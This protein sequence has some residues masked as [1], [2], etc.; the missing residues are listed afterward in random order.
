MYPEPN[1]GVAGHSIDVEDMY[2]TPADLERPP[3][4]EKHILGFKELTILPFG[5]LSENGPYE[6][7]VGSMSS[8]YQDLSS[9]RFKGKVKIK[10]LS[11]NVEANLGDSDDVATVNLIGNSLF[12]NVECTV[13][14]VPVTDSSSQTYHYKSMIVSIMILYIFLFV[15]FF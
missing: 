12:N 4:L 8:Y 5:G 10:K 14:G 13:Q 1:V 7:Q 3:E 2:D 15:K 11:T 6:F 9:V